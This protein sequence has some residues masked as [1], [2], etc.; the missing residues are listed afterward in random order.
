MK[1]LNLSESQEV[2]LYEELEKLRR[3]DQEFQSNRVV[4]G[5]AKKVRKK[6]DYI[7]LMLGIQMLIDRTEERNSQMKRSDIDVGGKHI[8]T[9]AQHMPQDAR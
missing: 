6:S 8:H 2:V 7:L 5:F 4:M 3:I 9:D 1:R